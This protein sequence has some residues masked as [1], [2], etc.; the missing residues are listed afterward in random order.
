MI[1][2]AP[3]L[4]FSNMAGADLKLQMQ[5]EPDTAELHMT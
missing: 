2:L 1:R 4:T 5:P 3:D